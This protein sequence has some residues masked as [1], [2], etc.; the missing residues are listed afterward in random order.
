[1]SMHDKMKIKILS[2]TKRQILQK[3]Y[4]KKVERKRFLCFWFQKGAKLLKKFMLTKRKL[5]FYVFNLNQDTIL[6]FR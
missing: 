1:M 2:Q 4:K 6:S 3:T 5:K